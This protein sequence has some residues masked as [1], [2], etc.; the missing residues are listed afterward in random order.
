MS[1]KTDDFV[2]FGRELYRINI[3]DDTLCPNF[4]WLKEMKIQAEKIEGMCRICLSN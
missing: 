1:L 3:V 2:K 4:N